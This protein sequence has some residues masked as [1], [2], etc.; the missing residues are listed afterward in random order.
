[1]WAVRHS[2]TTCATR[3]ADSPGYLAADK[4]VASP[5]AARAM[6]KGGMKVMKVMKVMTPARMQMAATE[7][8]RTAPPMRRNLA[9]QALSQGYGYEVGSWISFRTQAI[10]NAKSTFP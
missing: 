3:L 10:K 5:V 7:Q 6:P 1:M 8:L 9:P 4:R 2:E